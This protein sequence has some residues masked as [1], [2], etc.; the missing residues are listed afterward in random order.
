[1]LVQYEK[2]FKIIGILLLMMFSLLIV[3]YVYLLINYK[4][5]LNFNINISHY[6]ERGYI[7][8]SNSQI[9]AANYILYSIFVDPSVITKVDYYSN[10]LGK[11]LSYSSD[12]IKNLIEKNKNKKFLWIKRFVD[13]RV[14]D[15][16]LKMKLKGVYYVKE[17][18]R[19]YPYSE[20]TAP[21]LGYV[22]TYQ[23][24]LDGLEYELN[25]ILLTDKT[26]DTEIN[27]RNDIYLTINSYFQFIL[28][29]EL[30]KIYKNESPEWITGII[31]NAKNSKILAIVKL[32]SYNPEEYYKYPYKVKK[33]TPVT[34]IFEPGSTFKIFITAALLDSG[35]IDTN[36][37]TY[38]NG[39]YN[40]T[41]NI[42]IHDIERH[43]Y[44]DL[45]GIIKHSCNVG[46][47][48]AA[49]HIDKY[50]LYK[51]LKYFGFGTKTGIMLPGE[52]EGILK[53]PKYWTKMTK[54]IINIGQEVGVTA[55]QMINAFSSLING[56]LYYEP[57][58]IKKIVYSGRRERELKS[59]K[60]RRTISEETSKKILDILENAVTPGSTGRL[61]KID[62]VVM[63]GKT[64][65]AQIPSPQG[66]YYKDKSLASFIGFIKI[67]DNL[68]SIYIVVKDPKI[69]K[70]GGSVAAPAFKNVGEKIINYYKINNIKA[71]DTKISIPDNIFINANKRIVNNKLIPD[72]KGLTLK[73]VLYLAG[74]LGI[75]VK[76]RGSGFVTYQS[77]PPGTKISDIEVL[78][79]R[80]D[81][82][83]KNDR[84]RGN[85]SYK[86][87]NENNNKK[88][89]K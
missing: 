62:G 45:A 80:L 8:D 24:G 72:F 31:Q 13:K 1:M 37:R 82:F 67:Q 52:A 32:P 84:N 29:E 6:N 76:I 59:L 19:E 35:S 34:D 44:I 9:L 69:H 18:K 17:Y 15:E 60:I 51:Y 14:V 2:R 30:K 55:I 81:P 89:D 23:Q 7:Y 21:I 71:F 26:F 40:V 68:L 28:Y 39:E 53:K 83:I 61:A 4:D 10:T 85:D 56:G 86:N 74:K 12:K 22:N 64:G 75:K 3:R 87:N 77:Y 88:N 38:C 63:G 58:I 46:M 16:I 5:K 42:V 27:G 47:I 43:G 48:K 25:D 11:I 66:G 78:E 50:T 41:E 79:I 36:F 49:E 33:I 70:F 73:E 20:V 65:T 57:K 54:A